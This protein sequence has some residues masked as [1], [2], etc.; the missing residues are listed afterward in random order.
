MSN[1]HL[2]NYKENYIYFYLHKNLNS[3]RIQKN[4]DYTENLRLENYNLI[5]RIKVK[6]W[7]QMAKNQK[8]TDCI[9]NYIKEDASSKYLDALMN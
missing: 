2:D 7:Y 4:K 1:N 8:P 3:V 5:C 9:L 6:D